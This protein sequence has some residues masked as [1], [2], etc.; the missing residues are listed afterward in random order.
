MLENSIDAKSTKII[1]SLSNY[2]L[3]KLVVIDDG[4]G[5]G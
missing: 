5:I 3:K 4:V 1:I 2:G